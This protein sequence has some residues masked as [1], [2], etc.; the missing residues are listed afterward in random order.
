MQG[1]R[2]KIS[3]AYM[4]TAPAASR[5]VSVMMCCVRNLEDWGGGEY[6]FKLFKGFLLWWHP[7]PGF[8]F[9]SE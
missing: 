1:C 6:V 2:S 4:S 7:V 9:L 5:K 8:P 3:S